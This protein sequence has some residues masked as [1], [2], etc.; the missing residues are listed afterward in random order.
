MK[1]YFY[2]IWIQL[3]LF[4]CEDSYLPLLEEVDGVIVADARIVANGN[5][6]KII[7]YKSVGF[8]N[9]GEA[10]KPVEGARV[11]I[12]DSGGD[13]YKLQEINKGTF[14]ADL[15]Y[16]PQR[17]Y[18]LRINSGNDVYES[19]F[20]KVYETPALDSVYGEEVIKI[21]DVA[22]IR[23]VNDFEKVPGIQ[24]Y[25]DIGKK[26]DLSHYRFHARKVL[27][28]NYEIW[29]YVSGELEPHTMYAWKSISLSG[30]FNI[31]GPAEYSTIKDIYRHPIEFFEKYPDQYLEQKDTP[32]G[33]IYFIYLYGIS[34]Q[35]YNY[36][37]DLNSQLEANGKIFDP[38]YVQPRGTISCTSDPEK[39]ILGNFEIS[40][41]REYRYFVNYSSSGKYFKINPVGQ[42]YDIP[43]KGNKIDVPPVFWER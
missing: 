23:N 7:L 13:E 37:R 32:A 12:T 11:T 2:L 40:T 35:G 18:K 27:Q 33:W 4:S 22:G 42:F 5:G 20:E 16:N 24:V 1:K 17:T 25:A 19:E 31:A 8:N 15:P 10:Y 14:N 28:Y 6:N 43:A 30:V 39:P 34:E 3:F 9:K 26:G 41:L 29:L 21:P 38:M 36:Y